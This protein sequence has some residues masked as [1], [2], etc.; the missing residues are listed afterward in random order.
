MTGST[1]DYV[2]FEETLS[3]TVLITGI[4]GLTYQV[5][6]SQGQEGGFTPA[7]DPEPGKN[8]GGKP[9]F[10][11]LSLFDLIHP[12]VTCMLLQVGLLTPHAR[13]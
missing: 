4:S 8:R 11:T 1:A 5:W 13:N 7:H 12:F 3:K 6:L 2:G 9:T 10:P